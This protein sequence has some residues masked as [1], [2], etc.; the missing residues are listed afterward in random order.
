MVFGVVDFFFASKNAVLGDCGLH[1][2]AKLW[3]AG[4]T[5]EENGNL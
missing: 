4:I 2:G 1:A 5:V 3:R